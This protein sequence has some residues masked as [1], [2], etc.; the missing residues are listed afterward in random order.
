MNKLHQKIRGINI[1][2]PL[3]PF[4]LAIYPILFIYSN[5][6]DEV[7]LVEILLPCLIS[8]LAT[9]T[10]FLIF[11]FV[12]KDIYK[13]ALLT[14]I[15]LIIFFTF[16]HVFTLIEGYKVLGFQ[17]GRNKFLLPFSLVIFVA[18][19]ILIY[20]LKVNFAKT[21]RVLNLVVTLLIFISLL[22]I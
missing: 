15:V 1:E 20:R 5:N 7:F 22:T 6:L 12:F 10:I 16:G 9:L 21:S 14:T 19:S 11:K 18:S 13:S 3:Y 8:L 2:A 4:L 17:L